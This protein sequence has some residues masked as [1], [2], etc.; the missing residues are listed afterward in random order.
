MPSFLF[1]CPVTG[2][3][4]TGILVDE[5]LGDDPNFSALLRNGYEQLV[6]TNN[7]R[8]RS[9]FDSIGPSATSGDVRYSADSSTDI[10][11]FSAT[12]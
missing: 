7:R 10:C 6:T 12:K 8:M 2:E 3:E 11:L 4:V 1:R 5:A 9:F